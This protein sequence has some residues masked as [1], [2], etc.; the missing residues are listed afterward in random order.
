[1]KNRKQLFIFE[2]SLGLPLG[3]MDFMNFQNRGL[4][5]YK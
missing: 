2:F 3:L 4:W 5:I 1:M